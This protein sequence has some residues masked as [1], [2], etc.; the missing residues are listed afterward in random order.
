MTEQE[1]VKS[2][3]EKATEIVNLVKGADKE[4]TIVFVRHLNRTPRGAPKVVLEVRQNSN[5]Q[6][7]DLRA[8]F[9]QKLKD[10]DPNLPAKM[11]ISPVVRLATRVRIEILHSVANLLLRHDNSIV[12]AMCQQ[13]IPKPVI[14]IVRQAAG[15]SEIVRTMTFI[16]AV[17]WVEQNGYSASINMARAY[18]RAGSRFRGVLPQTFVLLSPSSNP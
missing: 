8:D 16:E 9:V 4:Y 11:N 6:A 17:C 7:T 13:Y 15:G 2:I 12:R 5:Q 10:K 18:E 3:R 14:M 1:K